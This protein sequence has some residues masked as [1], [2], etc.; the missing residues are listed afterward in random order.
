MGSVG[1]RDGTLF[2][3]S[4][5]SSGA[6]ARQAF[7]NPCSLQDEY[8]TGLRLQRDGAAVGHGTGNGAPIEA[9]SGARGRIAGGIT[10]LQSQ[11]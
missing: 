2:C 1:C 8:V 3:G 11:S 9:G 5:L 10:R 7:V 4:R 6:A